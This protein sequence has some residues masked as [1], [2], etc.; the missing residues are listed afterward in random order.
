MTFIPENAS[1]P[2]ILTGDVTEYNGRVLS[3][4]T[5]SGRPEIIPID[6]IERV[7]TTYVDDFLK[8]IDEFKAG[9]TDVAERLFHDA[10]KQER[11]E[12][13]KREILAWLVKCDLRSGDLSSAVHLFREL[14]RTDPYTLHWGT[15]PL[16]WAP[17]SVSPSLK[18]D[19]KPWLSNGNPSEQL[20]AAS[21]LLLDAGSSRDAEDTLR[22]LS[23]NTN[24]RISMLSR[25]QMW[26][27]ELISNQV[28][29]ESL[30]RWRSD[31]QRLP[32]SMRAGPQSLLYQGYQQ[33]G[34]LR[35]AAAEAL[36][37]PYVYPDHELLSA[38]ALFDAGEALRQTG[39]QADAQALYRELKV[40]Y[41]WSREAAL[42][43]SRLSEA[44]GSNAN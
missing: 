21:L 18:R 9:N 1:S 23:R 8:G 34:E 7:E 40:N 38:R 36:W 19:V 27:K 5:I 11:R 6:R 22:E 16:I 35:Q 26:R 4:Q 30:A 13:A 25:A 29:S 17:L 20:I 12:W 3:M 14:A 41:G 10:M 43:A 31:L 42:A 24:P 33:R 28:T 39:L 2:V 37:I 44:A 32:E 15:A